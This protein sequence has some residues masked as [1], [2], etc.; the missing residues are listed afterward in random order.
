MTFLQAF[1]LKSKTCFWYNSPWSLWFPLYLM[2]LYTIHKCSHVIYG[3]FS[4]PENFFFNVQGDH[5][6]LLSIPVLA[7]KRSSSF[8]CNAAFPRVKRVWEILV[9]YIQERLRSVH[10]HPLNI[11][12]VLQEVSSVHVW[13]LE[14][15]VA[16][17]HDDRPAQDNF[18]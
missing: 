17:C 4:S 9:T 13:H 8:Y 2:S 11:W 18:D 14:K 6:Q 3:L 10:M 7:P 5:Y 16:L 12:L 15:P 1:S